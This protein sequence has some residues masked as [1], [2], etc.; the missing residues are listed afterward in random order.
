M[1]AIVQICVEGNRAS[2]GR[3][4]ESL[5]VLALKN[6]WESYIA[7]GRFPRASKSKLIK[8]GT[9]VDLL[10]HGLQTRFLDRH[11][12]GSRRAT[13]NLIKQIKDIKPDIIHLHH[14]HG[15]YIN[16]KI[17]FN[18]LSELSIP[19]IWTFHDCWSITGH[20]CHF[21]Y[22]KCEKWKTECYKCPQKK[23]YPASYFADRSRKN[24]KLKKELFRSVS[25]MMIVNVSNWLNEIVRN[26]FMSNIPRQIIFNG[27]DVDLY[28]PTPRAN[29]NL[30]K[31]NLG[32]RDGFMILGVAS[33]WGKRKGFDDFI[34][35]S[36]K[37]DKNDFI[38]LV[39]LSNFQLKNLPSNIIA[40]ERTENKQELK[41]YYASADVF[42]NLSV[43]ETFGLTT[44]EA[45]SCGTPAIVYNATA[46]PEIID[47]DTGIV[48]DKNDINGLLNAIRLIQV[49]GK[50]AY[51][52]SCRERAVK[53]YNRNE[54]LREYIDL[55]EKM[56]VNNNPQKNFKYPLYCN[57]GPGKPGL[58]G[59]GNRK[60]NQNTT[61]RICSNCIMDTSD[62]NITFDENGKCDYCRNYEENILP[63]WH[64]DERGKIELMKIAAKIKKEGKGKDFDCI[65]GLS[66]GPDSSYTVYVAKEIMGLRPLLFHVDAGWNTQQAVSNIEKLVD[67]LSL[68][69]Y[70]EVINWEEMKDLQV[71]YFKSQIANIDDPQDIAF[72]S[73]LYKFARKHKIKYVLTGANYSTECCREP[74]EWGAYPGI[75]KTLVT[76]IHKRFGKIPLV[77]FP[78]VDV[79]TYKIFFKYFL[80]MQVIKPLNY[81][82]YLK[83]DAEQFLGSHF[84]WQKFQHK[85][86]ESRFTRFYE[87]FWLPKK[88]G[89]EK[90]RAHFSSLILTNQMKRE[91]ALKRIAHPEMS[92]EFL[93]QE[94]EYVANKLG[95]SVEELQSFFEG[96]NK[97]FHD[98]KNKRALIGI[99]SRAM[100]TLGLEKRLFR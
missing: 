98:Y 28:K 42:L 40:I 13:K 18:F 34:E 96:E 25:N 38:V 82:P 7:Y 48:V 72:F 64:T 86:H 56:L 59:L 46:C 70:T 10:F 4:A 58:S 73:T 93:K 50:E 21:D 89:Y 83:E 31:R 26:S 15:Y 3:I 71:A 30:I 87:D 74:E 99:G 65:I 67:G 6:G 44:A 20:C 2:V 11:G 23:E 12:L 39:G 17:L 97:T 76:D 45:L 8:I 5:G 1:P 16:I 14:L 85:H 66:G 27:V 37:I 68:D 92:A 94:F 77:S 51:S 24:Y 75:D 52:L 60:T 22:T 41:E 100:K 32:I 57:Q 69:L 33:V 54:R 80:G 62:P 95:L 53:Y 35:L 84:G 19:V 88:F 47:A 61:Y 81:V 29:Q 78:I 9:H 91:D 79:F 36:K 55:Y 43:E 49:K 63:T 90:R